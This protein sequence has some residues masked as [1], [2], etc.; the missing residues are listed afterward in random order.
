[1]TRPPTQPG[2]FSYDTYLNGVGW[3]LG[4]LC[5]L[6]G[7][8][9]LATVKWNTSCGAQ[10]TL[11]GGVGVTGGT[12]PWVL[13]SWLTLTV[14]SR[15]GDGKGR[16]TCESVHLSLLPGPQAFAESSPFFFSLVT[17][18]QLTWREDQ[19]TGRSVRD[20]T[21][22]RG[23]YQSHFSPVLPVELLVSPGP[24]EGLGAEMA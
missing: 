22:S 13:C 6:E 7:K 23:E 9:L 15:S 12:I 1:M 21:G 18:S 19:T 5:K 4:K 8:I 16:C 24:G 10:L 2:N 17:F 11:V 3:T 20:T 14:S